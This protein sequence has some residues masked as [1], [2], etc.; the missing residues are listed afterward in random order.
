MKT[1]VASLQGKYKNPVPVTVREGDGRTLLGA[2]LGHSSVDLFVTSP[3]Y[4]NNIDYSEVYKLELWVFGFVKSKSE[5]LQLRKSTLRSHPTSDLTSEL[6]TEFM[7]A[8]AREPLRSFFIP[9]S[10][11]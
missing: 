11:R 2:G 8:L 4:P 3:P 1:D 9:L 10:E 5:F 7:Q 6:D